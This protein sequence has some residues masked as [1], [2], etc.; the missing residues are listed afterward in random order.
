MVQSACCYQY[1]WKLSAISACSCRSS[2]SNEQPFMVHFRGI[3]SCLFGVGTH[4]WQA[5][6]QDRKCNSTTTKGAAYTRRN[7]DAAASRK[8]ASCKARG[9]CWSKLSSF[10]WCSFDWNIISLRTSLNLASNTRFSKVSKI[11]F[12]HARNKRR[13]RTSCTTNGY[14]FQS[15]SSRREGISGP[16]ADGLLR[17]YHPV[18]QR[19]DLLHH[20]Q[21]RNSDMYWNVPN[22]IH[23][24]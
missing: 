1:L 19:R 16:T 22:S 11:C 10:F 15:W 14:V 3:C 18:R 23:I 8:V 4:R 17:E 9:P 24:F 20:S 5:E 21:A 12:K 6:A 2:H 13:I 7:E